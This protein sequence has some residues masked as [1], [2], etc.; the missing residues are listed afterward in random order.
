MKELE[1]YISYNGHKRFS[2]QFQMLK[3][4]I[5]GIKA[6]GE[7]TDSE[8]K[9]LLNWCMANEEFRRYQPFRDL[10]PMIRESCDDGIITESEIADIVWVVDTIDRNDIL[11]DLQTQA[12]QSMH[13]IM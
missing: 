3:G 4:L 1:N 6:D 13:G 12:I 5:V 2:R 10:I 8:V 7:I 11:G 9:E